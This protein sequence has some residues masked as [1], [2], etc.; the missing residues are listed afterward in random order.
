ML[1]RWPAFLFLVFFLGPPT[2]Y[3][4]VRTDL[5]QQYSAPY[6][7]KFKRLRVDIDSQPYAVAVSELGHQ[8]PSPSGREPLLRKGAFVRVADVTFRESTIAFLLQDPNGARRV[9]IIFTFPAPLDPE[10]ALSSQFFHAAQSLFLDIAAVGGADDQTDEDAPPDGEDSTDEETPGDDDED[11]QE[12]DFRLLVEPAHPELVGDG[13]AV[14]GITVS[15]RNADGGLMTS[16]SGSVTVRSSAGEIY[17]ARASMF[18]GI[19]RVNLRSPLLLE[20]A[21]F[22]QRAIE[23]TYYIMRG[24]LGKP[25][26][27]RKMSTSTQPIPAPN[28]SVTSDKPWVYVVA[29]L[30]SVKGK[31]QVKI[32]PPQG[33]ASPIRGKYRG[34]DITGSTTWTFD[35]GTGI[36]MQVGSP[37]KIEVTW[38]GKRNMGFEEVSV[39]G[40]GTSVFPLPGDS[41]FL[42]APPVLFHRVTGIDEPLPGDPEPVEPPIPEPTVTLTAKKNPLAGDGQSTT[43]VIFQYLDANGRPKA[44]L[45]VKWALDRHRMWPENQRGRLLSAEQVTNRDGIATAIYQAPLTEARNTQETGTSKFRDVSVFYQEGKESEIVNCK[46]SILNAAPVYLVV[47]KPGVER[48][49]LPLQIGSLN[50]T[51]TGTIQLKTT[52]YRMPGMPDRMPLANAKVLLEGDEK[53]LKWAAVTPAMTDDDGSFEIKMS[54]SQWPRWDKDL[55]QPFVVKPSAQFLARQFNAMR[56]MDLWPGS[57]EVKLTGREFVLRAQEELA[58]VEFSD[59]EG[60]GEKIEIFAYML[61][62]LK[63]TRSDATKTAGEFFGHAKSLLTAVASYF[64]ADSAF[65]KYLNRKYK[66]LEGK[67]GL[68]K[69]KLLKARWERS[70]RKGDSLSAKI[71]RW[72]AAKL[73]DAGA[74][75]SPPANEEDS[76]RGR[77]QRN[78]LNQVLL[79][80][81]VKALSETLAK[82]L[83]E[84]PNLGLEDLITEKLLDPYVDLGNQFLLDTLNNRDYA[85]FHRIYPQSYAKLRTRQDFLGR[86][87]QHMTDWRIAEDYLQVTISTA[88]E[89]AQTSLKLL[90]TVYVQPNLFELAEKIEKGQK[91]LDNLMAGV[92]FMEEWYHFSR[93]LEKT[94]AVTQAVNLAAADFPPP[95]PMLTVP[96]GLD[97]DFGV[98]VHQA[99]IFGTGSPDRGIALSEAYDWNS[100]ALVEG[101]V[102]L[103]AVADLIAADEVLAEW[104]SDETGGLVALASQD[105]ASARAFIQMYGTWEAANR[106]SLAL[107]YASLDRP[108]V[109]EEIRQWDASLS[110]LKSA[111]AGLQAEI[112]SVAAKIEDL[113]GTGFT[114]LNTPGVANQL[115]LLGFQFSAWV[116]AA[117]GGGLVLVLVTA[118]ILLRRRNRRKPA[119]RPSQPLPVQIDPGIPQTRP[120]PPTSP[121][122]TPGTAGASFC[123]NCGQSLGSSARFCSS[124]GKHVRGH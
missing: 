1:K 106:R 105:P 17:P 99:G 109:D 70:Q 45:S 51:I 68:R 114:G 119:I 16:V 5:Q 58:E 32:L 53:I 46:I 69:L 60:L 80:Q 24:L 107:A 111:T 65:S 100:F 81:I 62:V 36:L 4:A 6:L 27:G 85:R 19:A 79:P 92:R 73:L 3:S 118:V 84:L 77:Y 83:P 29:E 63:N 76:M 49:T 41:F 20:P 40:M 75:V 123:S 39:G 72:L 122:M 95:P 64:Y 71:Y 96:A 7:K 35:A 61:L 88:S 86:E 50:G 12:L 104:Y 28:S 18:N 31:C 116:A 38:T 90:G 21:Q 121:P 15:A 11:E 10:F 82:Y 23:A 93:I 56:G 37:D 113:P 52:T 14:T 91:V 47:E 43:P 124:C 54:M 94:L 42:I 67:I 117:T 102:S 25:V 66:D 110:D 115:D 89:W 33:T 55:D 97:G 44:G 59:A 87:F 13:K 57:P 112:D 103:D 8:L 74:N 101:R 108:L 78:V 98:K 22:S 120:M 34:E 2:L 30:D 26:Q 9:P 48:A